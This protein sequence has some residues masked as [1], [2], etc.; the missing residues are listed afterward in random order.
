MRHVIGAYI[1]DMIFTANVVLVT[2]RTRPKYVN[3]YDMI[4]ECHVRV[5]S[6]HAVQVLQTVYVDNFK[7]IVFMCAKE[8]NSYGLSRRYF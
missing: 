6:Y 7:L 1:E 3:W 2:V 5:K 4:L 8:I